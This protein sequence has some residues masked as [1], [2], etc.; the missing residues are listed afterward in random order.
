MRV[1]GALTI[2]L[3]SLSLSLPAL[4]EGSRAAFAGHVATGVESA[5]SRPTIWDT[6]QSGRHLAI[7]LQLMDPFQAKALTPA[8]LRHLLMSAAGYHS[9]RSLSHLT[10][11]SP[12][13]K[14]RS[15]QPGDLLLIPGSPRRSATVTRDV[16]RVSFRS[17]TARRMLG[18]V[19]GVSEGQPVT[20][21]I[22]N[23][24]PAAGSPTVPKGANG[25]ASARLK[26]AC[27]KDLSALTIIS[28]VPTTVTGTLCPKIQIHAAL[29]NKG[30]T[31]FAL[32]ATASGTADVTLTFQQAL[33]GSVAAK[34]AGVTMDVPLDMGG[35]PVTIE[36]FVGLSASGST[37]GKISAHLTATFAGSVCIIADSRQQRWQYNTGAGCPTVDGAAPST[38]NPTASVGAVTGNTG[39]NLTLSTGVS[40]RVGI[41]VQTGGK[42]VSFGPEVFIGAYTA[43]GTLPCTHTFDPQVGVEATASLSGQ[44]DGWKDWGYSL[45][46][47]TLASKSWYRDSHND[48]PCDVHASI[49][50]GSLLDGTAIVDVEWTNASANEDGFVIYA[51]AP[52]LG[53]TIEYHSEAV[54]ANVA[55]ADGSADAQYSFYS[56]ELLQS[57]G[58]VC[59]QV[60]SVTRGAESE[61]SDPA[62]APGEDGPCQ[63][64][65]P[66]P[67]PFPTATA[68]PGGEWIA[69]SDGQTI[70]GNVSFSAHAYPVGAGDPAIGRVNFTVGWP[71]SSPNWHVACTAYPQA[72]TD[73]FSCS[74]D[75]SQL[76][77]PLGPVRI[78]FDVYDTANNHT[79]SPNG[80]RT[81]SWSPTQTCATLTGGTLPASCGRPTLTTDKTQ[82]AYGDPVKICYTV[83][84][85]Y[86]VTISL[87]R[88]DGTKSTVLDGNDDG[89]GGCIQPGLA[90]PPT[91]TRDVHMDVSV[92]GSLLASADAQYSVYNPCTVAYATTAVA[93]ASRC[94]SLTTDR[95]T[96]TV[97]Q[98]ITVC[99][100]MPLGLPA[101]VNITLTRPDGT[102][103]TVLD[104]DDDGTGGC[105]P[106]GTAADPAGTRHL[107]MT[108][109]VNGYNLGGFDAS[110]TVADNSTGGGSGCGITTTYCRTGPVC[111][112]GGAGY[113]ATTACTGSARIWTDR[114][115]YVVG[116][117]IIV[118][119]SVPGPTHVRITDT[120]AAGNSQIALER[121]DDGAGGCLQGMVTPPTGTE[122]LRLD[123][124]GLTDGQLIAT[125]DTSFQVYNATR[126]AARTT[127]SRAAARA[128][129]R[130]AHSHI[131]WTRV[132]PRTELQ[133]SA[134]LR[135][136]GGVK[137]R[138]RSHPSM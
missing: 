125:A 109:T 63:A 119:Y 83:P 102:S 96:Y 10:F 27:I 57:V 117:T 16:T 73:M 19:P 25:R 46:S 78:S 47:V 21:E 23:T 120:D 58:E 113:A 60:T 101:H 135:L 77:A 4:A 12:T 54:G 118:C 11:V 7:P 92:N 56:G 62:P 116:D 71:A 131:H 95:P 18:V 15:L 122:H 70:R 14:L 53:R 13:H 99:Y 74:R 49:L 114:S 103:G 134:P 68:R 90:G 32:V 138:T 29:S 110:Y 42:G 59:F 87:R 24:A 75:L 50:Q 129:R 67:T 93:T 86:H 51:W 130:S 104:G 3:L 72:G 39:S 107:H 35:V 2:A 30:Y 1:I 41:G 38:W 76:G 127:P 115:S 36:G 121:D 45:G 105:L 64:P 61:R 126:A 128:I 88:P 17:V 80:E 69:P 34:L 137:S 66:T 79:L 40:L 98:P 26:G 20:V 65:S 108:V 81:I 9:L 100:T 31:R 84:G 28:P 123:V 85:P 136:R 55:T 37:S 82:Y 33:P 52:W 89:T 43:L 111:G 6:Q 133:F 94:G 8:D 112:G 106:P 124:Y 5:G 132:T 48:V 91:G 97:G 22:V 44:F